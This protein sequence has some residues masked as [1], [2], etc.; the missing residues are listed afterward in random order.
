MG[1]VSLCTF[2]RRRAGCGVEEGSLYP[3]LRRLEKR[4]S[5]GGGMEHDGGGPARAIL[6]VDASGAEAAG[7]R[8]AAV[9]GGR[10]R[11]GASVEVCMSFYDEYAIAHRDA[12]GGE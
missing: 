9:D 12:R 4:R 11:R 8:R 6:P 3:A 7:Q 2:R 5:P 10:E 1:L